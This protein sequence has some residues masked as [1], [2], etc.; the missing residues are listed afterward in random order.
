MDY[1][2]FQAN[3]LKYIRHICVPINEASSTLVYY[4]ARN[5]E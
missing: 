2:I 1:F 4:T 3:Q 5:S